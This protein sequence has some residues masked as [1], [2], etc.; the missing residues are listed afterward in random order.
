MDVSRA[1]VPLGFISLSM[2]ACTHLVVYRLPADDPMAPLPA[3][4][5]PYALSTARI[6]IAVTVTLTA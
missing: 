4:A 6:Q 5:F 3:S 2:A 1:L